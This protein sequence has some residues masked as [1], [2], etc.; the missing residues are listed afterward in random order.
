MKKNHKNRR[1]AASEKEKKGNAFLEFLDTRH[2]KV[3]FSLLCAVLIL[4]GGV[5]TTGGYFLSKIG[6][7]PLSDFGLAS[8]IPPEE[9]DAGSDG[10][11]NAK[12]MQFANG[13]IMS[14][15][16]V[17]NILL[18]GSDTRGGEKYG[19]SDTMM[20]VSINSKTNQVKLVSFLRDLYVK[21]DGM[22]DTRINS[23][24]AYGGPKL[25][26]DTIQKN[27]RVKIDNYVNIDFQSFS[28][29]IDILGGVSIN[30]TQAEAK[31]LN[32]N[33]SYFQTGSVQRVSA[34]L[35]HLSGSG[36][37]AYARIRHIDSDFGRTSR[38]RK[39]ISAILSSLKRSNPAQLIGIAN[40]VFP[41][42][43]TDLDNPQ[44]VTLASQA[45]SILGND[46]EQ[47]AI[48][49][50]GAYQSQKI[51]GMSVLVPDIEKNKA[52]LWK[53]LYNIG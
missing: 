7:T 37:L 41:L 26:I 52:A 45:V 23:S 13:D 4:V 6:Y 33:P 1:Y 18:I 43:H 17:K 53:F 3:I 47:L 35:N 14:D 42:V 16:D 29:T 30:L 24:Y 27:F 31:E 8:S 46:T 2:G 38:Q 32:N 50:D 10:I 19:R 28:D 49:V 34:G 39:V 11:Q 51:R 48:P 36:A 40:S 20:L 25:L 22:Q 15:P 9:K 12:A 21:I 44:I 5:L